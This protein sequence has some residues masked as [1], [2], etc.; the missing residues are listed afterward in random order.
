MV[1]IGLV[2]S[3][4]N[5]FGLVGDKHILVNTFT[6]SVA[7]L[8]GCGFRAANEIFSN[9]S[10]VPQFI[11]APFIKQLVDNGYLI[12]S[13]CQEIDVLRDRYY[14]AKAGKNALGIAI[15]TTLDCNFRCTYCYESLR[16]V[17]FDVS[18]VEKTITYVTKNLPG[19]KL[20]EVIWWG[21]EPLTRVDLIQ[22]LTGELRVIATNCGAAY[23]AS[24]VTNG[25]NLTERVARILRECAVKTAQITLDADK[26]YHDQRRV[27]IN[28]R[29]TFE[30]IVANLRRHGHIFDHVVVRINLDRRNVGGLEGLLRKLEFVK[31]RL[32]LTLRPVTSPS[33]APIPEWSF[34]IDEFAEIERQFGQEAVKDGFVISYG[35]ITPGTTF[36]NAYQSQNSIAI[37]PSGDVQICPIFTGNHPNRF[38]E[39]DVQ[40]NLRTNKSSPQYAWV[41]EGNPFEDP[42]CVSCHALPVCMGSCLV[43]DNVKYR[44]LAKKYTAEKMFLRAR[45]V[46]HQRI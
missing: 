30:R 38:G 36:C 24:I 32:I 2:P 31:D 7:K 9:P 29:G 25:F 8:D 17:K 42:D 4:Y 15:G 20:L 35:F 33:N 44:C 12:P 27:L 23:R 40:G 1:D 14:L 16:T 10:V 26:E 5:V 19:K 43:K 11:S 45:S 18:T 34:E 39:I 13:S 37:D 3:R 28:G 46:R 21:G 41:Q 22:H 6:T